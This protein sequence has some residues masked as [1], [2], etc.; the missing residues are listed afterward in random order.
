MK[1]E[2]PPLSQRAPEKRTPFQ[3]NMNV[4]GSERAAPSPHLALI[5][6][7]RGLLAGDGVGGGPSGGC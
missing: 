6:Q 3:L 7:L 1:L 5:P 4:L 2:N